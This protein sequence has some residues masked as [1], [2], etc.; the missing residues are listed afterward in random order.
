MIAIDLD[1]ARPAHLDEALG[2]LSRAGAIPLA[3]GQ[4]LVPTLSTGSALAGKAK[5]SLLVDISHLA[6]L[7]RLALVDGCLVIGAAVTLSAVAAD[8]ATRAVPLLADVLPTVASFAVRNRGTLVGNLVSASP[9]SELPVVMVALG[10][11]LTLRS[12]DSIRDVAAV[13][14]FVGPH[15]TVLDRGEIVAEVRVPLPVGRA[16]GGFHEVAARSGA[17]PLCC[18]A[19]YLEA[20]PDDRLSI[21]RIAA[22]GVAGRP[23]RCA[24][25][26]A[27]LAG[28][29][30]GPDLAASVEAAADR[31]PPS[32][33]LPETEYA[34]A[35]L[36]VLLRRAVTDASIRLA[37]DGTATTG[38]SVTRTPS[39]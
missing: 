10:A 39:S 3:G 7:R 22:G 8:P 4:S 19:A 5:P 14:F 34:A 15:R 11:V 27:S 33:D 16:A 17:P 2:L 35:V 31:V 13:D 21:V 9:N 25:A 24:A 37:M 38:I 20:G 30:A 26:E 23:V 12:T 28:A 6:E 1:Y 36:P 18:V 32:P 29:A